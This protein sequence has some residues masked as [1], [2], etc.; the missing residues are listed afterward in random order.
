M[1]K[2]FYTFT[3][4][5]LSACSQNYT[6]R[7]M[8]WKITG[9][10]LQTP[11]YLF[12][13]FHTKDLDLGRLHPVVLTSLSKTQ[14][15]YTEIPLTSK[16]NKKIISYSRLKHPV[17]LKKRLHPKTIKLLLKY[18]ISHKLPYTLKSLKPFKTWA[19]TLMLEQDPKNMHSKALF[20]DEKLAAY[21]KMKHI[22]RAGL[23][24]PKEQLRYF[25]KLNKTQAELFLYSTLTQKN[26]SAY[27]K[28]LASWYQKGEE[29]GFYT[30]QKQFT[31]KDKKQQ[32]FDKLLIKGLLTE[33]N[34]RFIRRINILLQNS[35]KL[36]YFFAIGAGHMS[37]K[38]GLVQK[39]RALGYKISKVN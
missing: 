8:L 12:G 5:I 19:I 37:G 9:N 38:S 23:E 4:L 14:R 29:K 39:L 26:S 28:A 32:K 33:R 11:S 35:P 1:I 36:S 34:K 16:S 30:I 22:K 17:L 13:T 15:L 2:I 6:D 18:L 7:P 31:S 27:E 25:N 21:A 10:S 3:L 24:T 20:M